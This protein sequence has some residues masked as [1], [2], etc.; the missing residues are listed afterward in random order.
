[1]ETQ[2]DFVHLQAAE[3]QTA[4]EVSRRLFCSPAGLLLLGGTELGLALLFSVTGK[5]VS[6]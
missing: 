3:T 2:T 1:M 6:R 5:A 4:E